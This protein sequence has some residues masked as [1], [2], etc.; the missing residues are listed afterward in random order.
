[1]TEAVHQK[2]SNQS[3][4]DFAK[5]NLAAESIIMPDKNVVVALPAGKTLHS[6]KP[7]MAQYLKKPERTKGT[8]SHYT[9][10][11]FI[12][13]FNRFKFAG[14]SALFASE[15][16]EKP[17]LQG[18]YNYNASSTDP[19]WGDHRSI[20]HCQLSDEWKAWKKQANAA[21]SQREFAEFIEEN[22]DDVQQ[23]PDLTDPKNALLKEISLLLGYPFASQQEMLTLS[24]GVEINEGSKAKVAV[25]L[26]TGERTLQ[27]ENQHLDGEQ[28]PLKLPGL[29]LIRIPVFLDGA[30]YL[31]PVRL[32]YRKS[33]NDVV[34][35]F[36]IYRG[37]RAFKDAYDEICESVSKA[38]E[39]NVFVGSPEA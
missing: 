9:A 28:K 24:R 14:S 26:Q 37:D 35:L 39:T 1:M 15:N 33:G 10:A 19:N 16:A 32:R 17:Q 11:S 22:I 36:D 2:N 34:W 4:I 7:L 30:P 21:M 20:L 27:F 25:N 8:S 12:T 31:L 5:E 38:T 6:L 13:H 23:K 29:F 3:V 18:V